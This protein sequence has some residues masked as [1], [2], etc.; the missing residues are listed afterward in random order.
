M[1]MA[2][3]RGFKQKISFYLIKLPFILVTI[4]IGFLLEFLLEL[5]FMVMCKL[6][7][8]AKDQRPDRPSR[9]GR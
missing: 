2:H 4:I 8:T 1:E 3:D 6:D 5:P 9:V 7:R